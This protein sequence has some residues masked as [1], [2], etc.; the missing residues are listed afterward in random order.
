MS[1]IK[2]KALDFFKSNAEIKEVFATSDGFLFTKKG[3]ATDHAKVLDADNP[4]VERFGNTLTDF[5]EETFEK[6]K[7]SIAELKAIKTKAVAEYTE[8]FGFAPEQKLSAKD[9]QKLI[10]AKKAESSNEN[11]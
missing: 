5:V 2:Q 6:A 4:K 9:I 7:L 1:E 3:D 8:L 11:N 10:D